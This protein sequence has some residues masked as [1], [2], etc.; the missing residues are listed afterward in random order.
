MRDIIFEF[1]RIRGDEDA[2]QL[3]VG[4]V[5]LGNTTLSIH[6]GVGVVGRRCM[7]GGR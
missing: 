2:E 6:C 3:V 4:G 7:C 5:I 1:G